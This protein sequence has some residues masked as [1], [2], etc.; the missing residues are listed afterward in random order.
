[1]NN[2]EDVAHF[3]NRAIEIGIAAST[4][5][6]IF[7]PTRHTG[8]A[9]QTVGSPAAVYPGTIPYSYYHTQYNAGPSTAQYANH[10]FDTGHDENGSGL[11]PSRQGPTYY[12]QAGNQ[13]QMT[14][15][16]GLQTSAVN[17][18]LQP[19]IH[20]SI[21][22][23]MGQFQYPQTALPYGQYQANPYYHYAAQQIGS[24][25]PLFQYAYPQ[26]DTQAQTGTMPTSSAE[27][28]ESR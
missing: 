18:Q 27:E 1:M 2:N 12:P 21:A 17:A 5:A 11:S 26:T 10:N 19:L 3:Y 15:S 16:T 14:P 9:F 23:P 24:G 8:E 20:P 13:G 25:A 22:Q 7:S 6:E 28:A 4:A